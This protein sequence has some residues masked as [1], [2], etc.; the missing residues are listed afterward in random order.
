MSHLGLGQLAVVTKLHRSILASLCTCR[1][2]GVHRVR[3]NVTGQNHVENHM[4]I[5]REYVAIE[6]LN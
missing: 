2:R 6:R 4:A 1:S 5:S 3:Q